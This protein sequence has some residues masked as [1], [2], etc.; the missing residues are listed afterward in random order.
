MIIGGKDR[1]ELHYVKNQN[2]RRFVDHLVMPHC[3]L[4][5]QIL[6]KNEMIR[7]SSLDMHRQISGGIFS[8]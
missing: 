5:E 3:V 4:I 2:Q 8:F 6:L 7:V 1:L